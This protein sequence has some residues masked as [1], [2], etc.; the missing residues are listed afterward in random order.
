MASEGRSF[1]MLL[2]ESVCPAAPSGGLVLVPV[3]DPVRLGSCLARLLS[4]GVATRVLFFDSLSA[5][6]SNL[7]SLRRPVDL[8]SP[9]VADGND[10]VRMFSWTTESA[11][12]NKISEWVSDVRRICSGRTTVAR[13][14]SM[15]EF[16]VW[17]EGNSIG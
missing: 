4:R 7:S 12:L 2:H 11:G 13:T 16:I 14:G 17:S 1:E 3:R 9:T 5:G 10:L 15:T 6:F 8:D